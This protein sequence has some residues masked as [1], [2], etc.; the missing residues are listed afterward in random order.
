[1]TTTY[2]VLCWIDK[3][4]FN[5]IKSDINHQF[6]SRLVHEWDGNQDIYY[7]KAFKIN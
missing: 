7:I 1:M 4:L 3:G 5:I 2:H 6:Y